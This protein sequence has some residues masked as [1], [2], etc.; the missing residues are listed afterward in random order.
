MRTL[1][2]FLSLALCRF[3]SAEPV[4]LKILSGNNDNEVQFRSEA[5][6]ETVIG[7]TRSVSGFVELDPVTDTF[8]ARGEV[9]VQLATLKT[10]NDM[11]DRHM[12]E[13]H[14]ETD[15][16]PEAVFTLTQLAIPAGSLADGKRTP[17]HV[18]GQLKLHG[19][20]KTIEPETYLTYTD[21]DKPTLKI[22]SL[23][24]VTLDDYS[25]SRPQ[26]LVLRLAKTQQV[27]VVLRAE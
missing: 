1:I 10:G 7:K 15:R 23:F 2:I 3:A 25:I 26:F 24:P 11:R 18:T 21:G 19:V 6:S 20:E 8:A 9:H 22:E 16:F 13:N 27:S 5:T 14:L 17:V 12:R 4:S